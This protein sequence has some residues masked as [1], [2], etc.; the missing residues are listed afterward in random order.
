[1]WSGLALLLGAIIGI[2]LHLLLFCRFVVRLGDWPIV[3]EKRRWLV[4]QVVELAI[5]AVVLIVTLVAAHFCY[6]SEQLGVWLYMSHTAL[7]MVLFSVLISLM[8]WV[9]TVFLSWDDDED[10]NYE[11]DAGDA[12][13]DGVDTVDESDGNN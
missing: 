8:D 6:G 2:L 5:G 9:S 12:D 7:G 13:N 3:A 10:E 11:E 4:V 1:M